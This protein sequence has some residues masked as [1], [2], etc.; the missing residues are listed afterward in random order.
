MSTGQPAGLTERTT[1]AIQDVLAGRRKG[2]LAQLLFAG[3]AVIASI[4]YVDPGNF[5]TNLQAGAEFGYSLLWVVLC[6]NLIAMLFQALS[7]K[8]GIVTQKN[9]AQLC[10]EHLP[11][12]LVYAMWAVSEI[13][14]MATDLAEFLGGAIGLSLLL[15]LPLMEGMVI[16]G[17]VTYAIL[18]MEQQGY[19]PIELAI[20]AFVSIIALCYLLEV[21]V[22]PVS[23]SAALHGT[24]VPQLA[25][26]H[27][28]A[29]SAG[30]LGATVMPH[31]IYL[32]SGLTQNRAPAKN[33]AERRTLLSFSNK[34]TVVALTIA[35]MVNMAMVVM[36]SAAFHA[37]HADIA[38][39]D[40]AWRTLTPLLG[41][42][43]A[44]VFL[45]SLLASGISSSVVGT[46]AG[47][48]IMQGFVGFPV[49][50]WVR[51]L[52]TMIPAFVVIALGMNATEAL[53]YSQ[54]VLSFA[55]PVPM[56]AL[57]VFTSRRDIMGEFAN[58]RVVRFAALSGT[59]VV[60]VLNAVL[61]LQTFG[62]SLSGLPAA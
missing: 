10:R 47:Q 29:V 9:L 52:V 17:I 56:I 12:K 8:L 61:I 24:L 51:R 34:E 37:G 40:T 45:V 7:A 13:A 31:A 33:N 43:A 54:V 19:R 46:M 16:T 30:I 48:M 2:V 25:S 6:A 15:H 32:H 58:S 28:L 62:V 22:A 39:V 3:P 23:W 4:A 14:A 50:V 57:I 60:L 26:N 11:R 35:G 20:G 38:D 42:G 18:L 21:F 41:A 5:A 44:A 59:V 27:A 53:V 49:P 1:R 55:L 36:A